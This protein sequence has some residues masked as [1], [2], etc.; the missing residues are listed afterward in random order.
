MK[1]LLLTLLIG[2]CSFIV[3]SQ[4]YYLATTTEL[5]TYNQK[6]KDWILY[7]KMS[8]TKINVV[9]EE[10]F[11]SFQA[12]NPTFYKIDNKTKENIG[13]KS[14]QGFRYEGIDLKTNEAC[15]IDICKF[16]ET[17][18]MISIVKVGLY[19][20]RYFLTIE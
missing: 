16:T 17:N 4:S 3:Q 2:L 10:E 7:Q 1:K 5:Y 6:Q 11:V 12:K 18:Y 19:N 9:V 15:Y 20:L 13:G 14:F 8:D